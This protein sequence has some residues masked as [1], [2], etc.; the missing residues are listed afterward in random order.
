[1][2]LNQNRDFASEQS[3]LKTGASG[4]DEESLGVVLAGGAGTRLA[5]LTFSVSKQLLPVFDKPMIYYPLSTLILA[6]VKR[7]LVISSEEQLPLF[8]R[9]LLDGSQWGVKISYAVQANAE[10]IPQALSIAENFLSSHKFFLILGDNLFHGPGLGSSLR[11]VSAGSSNVAFSVISSSPERF[12]VLEYGE[13]GVPKRIVEKPTFPPSRLV[14]PGLYFF[15]ENPIQETASLKPSSRGELEISDLLNALLGKGSLEI[16]SLPRGGAWFDNGTPDS[17]LSASNFV[18]AVQKAQ[19]LLVGSP[20]ESSW[21]VGNISREQLIDS[22][23]RLGKTS[24]AETLQ[25]LLSE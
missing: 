10:G 22:I 24:Y 21:R 14:V 23:F 3:Q 12:G 7:I 4:E 1:M 6:G 13:L 2:N 20:E 18:S 15:S 9:A 5:P 25:L 8:E 16:K 11:R 19:G 17:L